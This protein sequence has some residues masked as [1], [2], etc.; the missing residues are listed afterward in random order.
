MYY[1]KREHNIGRDSWQCSIPS[2]V[3]GCK[4]DWDRINVQCF[5]ESQKLWLRADP[6]G[7]KIYLKAAYEVMMN[8]NRYNA[9]A[10]SANKVLVWAGE[11]YI[12]R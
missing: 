1:N 3:G 4:V 8:Q 5:K 9:E 6:L 2:K 7:L 12:K 11:R 10:I